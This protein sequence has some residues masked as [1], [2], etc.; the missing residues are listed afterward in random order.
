M[1]ARVR[2]GSMMSGFFS[3]F[4]SFRTF[5][6]SCS[7]PS[8]GFS[9]RAMLFLASLFRAPACFL[10]PSLEVFR[11]GCGDYFLDHLFNHLRLL[12]GQLLQGPGSLLSI[13]VKDPQPL[14]LIL[15]PPLPGQVEG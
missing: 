8:L 6:P 9:I 3:W 11:L 5:L 2:I 1:L 13:P 7:S 15:R 10:F 12:P 14:G 4:N